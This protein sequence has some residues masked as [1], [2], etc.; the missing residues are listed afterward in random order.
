MNPSISGSAIRISAVSLD[1]LELS[2]RGG[3]LLNRRVHAR[4][5]QARHVHAR[6]E[7][8]AHRG[9]KPVRSR[10]ADFLGGSARTLYRSIRRLLELPPDTRLYMCHDYQAPGRDHYAWQTRPERPQ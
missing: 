10:R 6:A 7:E 8:S 5:A 3:Q 9:R 4:G 1:L 2:V